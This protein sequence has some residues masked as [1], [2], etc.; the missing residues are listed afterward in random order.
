MPHAGE[1]HGHA[2]LVGGGD[3]FGI[4]HRTARLDQR[5]HASFRRG[6]D[7][8]PEREE[9]VGGHDR[10]GDGQSG[11][12]RLDGGNAGRVDAAH[13]PGADADGLLILRVDDRVGFDELGY[14]PGEQQIGQLVFGRGPSGHDLQVGGFNAAVVTVLQQQAARDALAIPFFWR[15]GIPG[16]GFQHANVRFGRQQG[17]GGRIDVGREDDLDELPVD[18]G[19]G[20][21]RIQR[22]VEGDDAAERGSRVG[23]VG[24]VIGLGQAG[25]QRHAAGVGMLDDDAGRLR[26]ETLDAL[27]RRVGVGD[28]VVGEFLALDLL[29]RGN[30]ATRG[31]GFDVESA[32]L[33]RIFAITHALG[34]TKAQHQRVG[35][36]FAALDLAQ[37]RGDGGVVGGGMAEALDGQA[38]AAGV[39]QGATGGTQFFQHGG[40]VG[41]IDH[42]ADRVM[43][44]GRGADHGR[45]ADV[46]I[47]DGI[48]QRAIGLGHGRLE[49]IE[50]HDHKIDWA[51]AMLLHD[52]LVGAAPTEDAAVN[53]GMQRLDAA[54]HHFRE[55]GVFR[56]LDRFDA[57]LGQGLVRTT[58]GQDFDAQFPQAS[59]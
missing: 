18:D 7:A 22:A 50:V 40:V 24:P 51:D 4:P 49:G 8:I 3:D 58:R 28:V 27:Q 26:A 37:V 55:A 47:L 30:G 53:A 12:L 15:H 17:Q 31:V 46:D 41:G 35:E 21:F 38:E 19:L 43:V 48:L 6:V 34:M 11:V 32:L 9:G 57:L 45:S 2:M 56:N 5:G 59:G 42:H 16:A 54:A 23:R 20:R 44:L 33:M 25:A 14:P 39:G 13:L 52:G 36:G 1:D 29:G 10:A